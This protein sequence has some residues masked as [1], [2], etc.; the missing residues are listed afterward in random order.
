[1]L[2]LQRTVERLTGV[3]FVKNNFGKEIIMSFTKFK[4]MAKKKKKIVYPDI[5]DW[6]PSKAYQV[7]GQSEKDKNL[8]KKKTVLATV[9][10]YMNLPKLKR[11]INL[12]TEVFS[13]VSPFFD[14]PSVWNAAKSAF[15]VSK[16][17]LEE[18]EIW[19][20]DYFGGDEWIPPY[21][22]DFN[23]IILKAITGYE[24]ET[25]RTSDENCV[26]RIVD[27][28]GKSVGYILNT[29]LGSVENIFIKTTESE[30]TRKIIKQL[31]WESVKDIN[32]VLRLN[33][34]VSN[35]DESKIVFESDDAFHP[36]MSSRAIEYSSYLK[37]CIDAGVS[38][39]VMLYG[40]PGTGKSTLAR[41]IIDRLNMRSFRIRVEDIADLENSTLFEAISIFEPDSIILD[42]FDRSGVQIQLL[43]TLEF[44]QRH[45][46]LVIATVNDRNS[47]DEAILR[48]G[49]FDELLLIKQM[50]ADVVK[51]VLGDE[52]KDAYELVKDWPIAFIQEYAKRRKFMSAEE[53]ANSTVELANRVRR[54]E[55]YD[56]V[57]D[58]DKILNVNKLSH[59]KENI[60]VEPDELSCAR[61]SCNLL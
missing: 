39:S 2:K 9:K 26:I 23:Q 49:R 10:D 60:D 1:M 44:F 47:L 7:S 15:S 17:L 5:S 55:K 18:V 27:V 33:K 38:R 36:M 6:F 31:L 3:H 11:T 53:A 51:A 4:K 46:K 56:D 45:V 20:D 59:K 28:E 21:S 43:E 16:L 35:I 48:P 8:E 52:H 22:R 19:S 50:D 24:Y 32:L 12:G 34:K 29:K 40:P 57:S 61:T 14:N 58:L 25:I 42:D 54:L 41:T 13:A 37:R 30:Q